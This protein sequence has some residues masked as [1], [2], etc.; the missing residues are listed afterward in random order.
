MIKLLSSSK[1]DT[2][3]FFFFRRPT[4]NVPPLSVPRFAVYSSFSFCMYDL[5]HDVGGFGGSRKRYVEKAR[6]HFHRRKVIAA[7]CRFWA[8]HSLTLSPLLLL[9][10]QTH[11]YAYMMVAG[12]SH[13]RRKFIKYKKKSKKSIKPNDLKEFW[14]YFPFYR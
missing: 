4:N 1:H 5:T 11:I 8:P 3:L 14:H 7:V 9:H 12:L 2:S 6:V 13:G 10:T